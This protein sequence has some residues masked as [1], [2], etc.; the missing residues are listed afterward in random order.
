MW[1]FALYRQVHGHIGRLFGQMVGY[2][3][4]MTSTVATILIA[5]K[6]RT[7]SVK[8]LIANRVKGS[9][10]TPNFGL[11]LRAPENVRTN[12]F[13]RVTVFEP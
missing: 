12:I 4:H 2:M 7:I 6:L 5:V 10:N 3:A 8:M 13:E 11:E 1:P 9:L